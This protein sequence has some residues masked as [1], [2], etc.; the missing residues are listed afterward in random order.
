M[1]N[2]EML[3]LVQDDRPHQTIRQV[4][5]FQPNEFHRNIFEVLVIMK[6]TKPYKKGFVYMSRLKTKIPY[7][8]KDYINLTDEEQELDFNWDSWK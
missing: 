8:Q 2:L 6:G 5:Y 1:T 7:P 3:K 4:I